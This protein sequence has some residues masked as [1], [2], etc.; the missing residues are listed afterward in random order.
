MLD[1]KCDGLIDLVTVFDGWMTL[2]GHLE[3]VHHT[4]H[5]YS[6]TPLRQG[7]RGTRGDKSP[8]GQERRKHVILSSNSLEGMN[9]MSRRE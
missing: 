3:T 8:D 6:I 5:L 9:A 2:V 7:R 4:I 1:S